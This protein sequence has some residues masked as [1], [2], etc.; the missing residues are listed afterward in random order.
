MLF[1]SVFSTVKSDVTNVPELKDYWIKQKKCL[2][3]HLKNIFFMANFFQS[4]TLSK[5]CKHFIQEKTA[6]VMINLKR[7]VQYVFHLIWLNTDLIFKLYM[8]SQG[9]R[10]LTPKATSE[11]WF[12]IL[13]MKQLLSRKT[14]SWVAEGFFYTANYFILVNAEILLKT[15]IVWNI[16]L[17]NITC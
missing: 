9:Q 10:A 5:K 17:V 4:K 14:I 7:P 2:F 16:K 11:T 15:V 13:K 3:R 6:Q 8:Q 1:L 12:T